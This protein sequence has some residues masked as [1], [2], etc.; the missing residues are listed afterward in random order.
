MSFIENLLQGD[1]KTIII[2]GVLILA[3]LIYLKF[4]KFY[5]FEQAR[6]FKTGRRY[7]GK[8]LPAYTNGWFMVIRSEELK[9]GQTKYVDQ[10]GRNAAFFRGEDKKVYAVDAY[11]AHM[12]ANLAIG[13]KVKF[14]NCIQCPFHGWTFDGATGNCV[15]GS[16][17]IPREAVKYTY[18]DDVGKKDYK[19]K[20]FS[21]PCTEKV[22]IETY[23][24]RE[25]NGYI[26]VWYHVD[27]A[28]AKNPPYEPFDIS[29]H[30]KRLP[31]RGYSINKVASHVQDIPENGGDL[32]HFFYIHA[33]MLP[34]TDLLQ[35]RWKAKWIR[36]DDPQL[37]EK[38]KHEHPKVQAYK[39]ALLDKYLNDKNKKY[40]GC[41]SLDNYIN[42]P[43]SGNMFFFNASAFQV[44]PGLVYLFLWSP[45]FETV[46]FQHMHTVDKYMQHVYHEIYTNSYLPYWASALMLRL[47]AGQVI[48]DGVVWDNKRFAKHTYYNLNAEPDKMLL[49]WRNWFAQFYEGCRE[50]EDERDKYNW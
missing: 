22:S 18:C 4:Y 36:A 19:G 48:N 38:L 28:L 15:L 37:R 14:G 42:I 40:I 27:P 6:D 26:Y 33:S 44:G 11:C 20:T 23:P 9:P 31:H 3:Y 8:T 43:G 7:I 12:G 16:D 24:V 50:Y 10:N 2:T 39:T 32:M 25:M 35:A 41:L 49:E 46:F 17:K 47:E 45:F 21:E 13:G 30:A 1:L 34:F 5:I 29:E